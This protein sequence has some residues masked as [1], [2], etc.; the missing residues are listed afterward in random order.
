MLHLLGAICNL[1][2]D[3]DLISVSYAKTRVN[4][5]MYFMLS[6]EFI[7]NISIKCSA[8]FNAKV[9]MSE[10]ETFGVVREFMLC[11]VLHP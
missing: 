7:I 3:S 1:E 4:Q 6:S 9:D 10:G 5:S 8:T 2:A 11:M